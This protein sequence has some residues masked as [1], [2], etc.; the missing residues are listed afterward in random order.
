MGQRVLGILFGCKAT[1]KLQ[2]TFFTEDEDGLVDYWNGLAGHRR[3]EQ[4]EDSDIVGMWV[5]V[6]TGDKG[7]PDISKP[8]SLEALKSSTDCHKAQMAW[9]KF[10]DWAKK[11]E[12]SIP[13][14]QLFIAPVEVA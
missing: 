12:V 7:V 2:K 3:I 13:P 9:Q 4:V 6:E 8:V 11:K 14:A 10:V 5:F 1:A